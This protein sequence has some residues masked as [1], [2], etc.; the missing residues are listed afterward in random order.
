[1]V[2]NEAK[3]LSQRAQ[4]CSALIKLST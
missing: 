2:V 1:M 4:V 3:V